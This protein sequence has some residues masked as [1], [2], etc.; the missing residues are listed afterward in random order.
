[1]KNVFFCFSVLVCLFFSAGCEKKS[2]ETPPAAPA[3]ADR[4][5]AAD[6]PR[7]D[8][9]ETG[10]PAIVQY[11]LTY[12]AGD[13]GS[14]D[15]A[16]HQTVNHGGT[17]SAVTAVPAD[18]YHFVSW[19]DGSTANPRTDANV[20][21]DLAVTARFAVNQYSMTYTAGD[22]GT[23]DGAG[24]Q[25]VN[26]GSN[27]SAVRAVPAEGY[28][29]VNWSDG[30][31]A[32]PR[33]DA[34]V[35]A[36]LAVTASFALNQYTLT[37]TAEKNG[38]IDGARQQTVDHGGEGKAVTAVADKGYHFESW[39][40]GSTANPRTDVGVTADLAV[41]ANFA[42]NTYRVGGTV[43]GLAEGTAVV[44]QNKGSD[45]LTVSTN[46]GFTFASELPE[47]RPYGVTVL[48]QPTT[49][50][51][52]C[53]VTGGEGKIPAGNVTG[54]NVNCVINTYSV[55][56]TVFGLPDGDQVV[57]RNNKGDDLVVTAN[58]NFTFAK[59]LNDGSSYEVA[60]HS[61]R[62]KP[63]WFCRVGNASG[64]LAGSEV[65]TVDV[66]CFPEVDL[67]ALAGN[68]KIV[69][70]WNSQD[71]GKVTFNLCRAQAEISGGG[72]SRCTDFKGGVI[73]A[74]VNSPHTVSKLTNEVPYWLQLEVI[75]AGDR[76]TY[77]AVVNATPFGALNDTGIDWCADNGTNRNMEGTREEK[78]AGCSAVAGTHPRQDAQQG[79][80]AAAR[81][82]KLTKSGSGSAGFD[83]TKICMSG[84]VAGEGKC[85]PNPTPG[86]GANNWACTLDNV[87]GLVWEAKTT[88]GMHNQSNTYTWHNPD[89][90][91]NGGAPGVQKGGRCTGSD[92]DTF[93]YVQAVNAN[94]LCGAGDWRLPTRKELLSIVDNG[95]FNPA[96]DT[97]HFPNTPA[98]NY[99]SSSTYA[100]QPSAAWQVNFRYGEVNPDDKGQGAHVR[101]VR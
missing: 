60:I 101:L 61:Q 11:A 22:H 82:R 47:G 54:I 91:V 89:G 7:T 5:S 42:I 27:S 99:W 8:A 31:T 13:N 64:T 57:L 83:F 36:N 93:A 53:T 90:T 96:V 92:C 32:N 41:T 43:S 71:F 18:G 33:T 100:D 23:V 9:E 45:D 75:H 21:A 46:G 59:E 28:H 63:K 25:K 56:G 3:T 34:N 52:T 88:G 77:S 10:G 81:A 74:K 62:L 15:G 17:G 79:R 48:T 44:L 68:R 4:R 78:A 49:P 1:M 76:R 37:Y 70:K 80:D 72:F 24:S 95:R 65:T 26:H 40:D 97:G 20:T 86:S 84:E 73:K 35:T 2:T 16:S 55:G 67:Q 14:I 30:S 19:S 85:P 39:S 38:T 6:A 66:G 98:S 94:G 69:L 50:N 87:T 12:I 58:G 51:Q 29:F